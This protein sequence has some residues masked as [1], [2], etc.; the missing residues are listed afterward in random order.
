MLWEQSEKPSSI[1]RVLAEQLRRDICVGRLAPDTKLKIDDLRRTYGGSANSLREALVSLANEGLVEAVDQRGFRVSSMTDA[2]LEDITKLRQEIEC[3]ALAWSMKNGDVDWEA[4]L[5]A[6][7]HKLSVADGQVD[8]LAP[9]TV[10]SRDDAHKAFHMAL[11]AACGSH[12]LLQFQERLYDESRRFRLISLIE[13]PAGSTAAGPPDSP[14]HA[15]ILEAV[16]GRNSDRAVALL[17]RH[18]GRVLEDLN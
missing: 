8:P 4:E 7:Y 11:S 5:V 6:T 2:D 13:G 17:R 14:D 18:I 16:T 3:L 15:A 1:V 10:L 12:R 9:N